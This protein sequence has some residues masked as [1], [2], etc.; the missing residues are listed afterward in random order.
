M[1]LFGMIFHIVYAREN[2]RKEARDRFGGGKSA[3][4]A[5]G[6][7]MK[8]D[9]LVPPETPEERDRREERQRRELAK[10]PTVPVSSP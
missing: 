4:I 3:R 9:G 10:R 6:T 1:S 5:I 7:A 2:A 8:N